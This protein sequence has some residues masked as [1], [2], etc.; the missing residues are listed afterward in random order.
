MQA[1]DRTNPNYVDV[2]T[3]DR[4]L[5]RLLAWI[6]LQ[7]PR[8]RKP[9]LGLRFCHDAVPNPPSPSFMSQLTS[10]L[11]EEGYLLLALMWILLTD[12]L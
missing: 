4:K 2:A 7:K 5:G 10:H 11:T 6:E 12:T 9:E 3:R 1:P 8:L